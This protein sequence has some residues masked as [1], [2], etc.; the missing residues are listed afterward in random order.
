M[1]P[2]D[3]R[4]EGAIA[5]GL[6]TGDDAD[7]HQRHIDDLRA[8]GVRIISSGVQFVTHEGG[9]WL[10]RDRQP[11]LQVSGRI[12]AGDDRLRAQPRGARARAV[13]PHEQ[14]RARRGAVPR[15]RRLRDRIPSATAE[16]KEFCDRWSA[17]GL[18]L[19]HA[20]SAVVRHAHDLT[21]TRFLR[22][23]FACG[24]GILAFRL[25]RRARRPGPFVP[26]PAR[27]YLD[28]VSSPLRRPSAG[29]RLRLSAL[30]IVAQLATIAGAVREAIGGSWAWPGRAGGPRT[31]D[32][33]RAAPRRESSA[34]GHDGR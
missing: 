9:A 30:L 13:L 19:A 33:N 32:C 12:R 17:H 29:G 6:R 3:W 18:A 27:F 22:Q 34:H 25:I 26:E 24:R 23:H 20:P 15:R 31:G 16:D 28:L 2:S 8:G 11:N 5:R 1:R 7:P 4:R 10:L 21:F 14:H